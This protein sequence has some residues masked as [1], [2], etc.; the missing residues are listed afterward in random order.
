MKH[1]YGKPNDR[2]LTLERLKGIFGHPEPPKTV[3]ERQF[4]YAQEK[5]VELA[6]TSLEQMNLVE[7]QR[8]Y[9]DDL[10]YVELQPELFDYLF[11]ACLWDWHLSLQASEDRTDFHDALLERRLFDVML[12]AWQRQQVFLFLQ[13]SALERLHQERGLIT[14]ELTQAP[15]RWLQ[16]WNTLGL[17]LPDVS[18]LW[19]EWERLGSVGHAVAAVQYVA[20][21][22]YFSDEHPLW[23]H[24][25]PRNRPRNSVGYPTPWTCDC[26]NDSRGWLFENIQFFESFWSVQ[27]LSDWLSRS[28]QRLAGEPEEDQARMILVDFPDRAELVAS[29]LQELPSHLL[30]MDRCGWDV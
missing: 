11:P 19:V 2:S 15:Y 6:G 9:Y 1:R 30:Q 17:L 22:M 14:Q 28:V 26:S 12:T 24:L 5:L 13:D 18:R 25:I 10:R 4:D 20:L 8:Y 29:R 3:T 27:K 21:F 23:R 16:R 7:L